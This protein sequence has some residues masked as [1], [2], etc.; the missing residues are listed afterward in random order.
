MVL[1]VLYFALGLALIIKGGDWFV[2]AS[3]WVAERTGMPKIF[4]GATV[5][6]LATTL[7]ELF[8]SVTAVAKGAVGLGIGNAIG[9]VICNTGLI[10]GL[11]IFIRPPRIERAHFILKAG[12]MVLSL[13]MLLVF[14]LDSIISIPEALALLAV[15]FIF[16]YVSLKSA[17]MSN[18]P[19]EKVQKQGN[20]ALN[21]LKFT[22][23]A[24]AIVIGAQLLVSNA[25]IIASALG[26]S[27][28]IIGLTVIALGT[29]LPELV[30]T[31][32]ALRKKE[33]AIGVGNI[34]GANIINICLVL[35]ASTFVAGRLT[36][37]SNFLPVLA[38]VMPRTLYIDIPVAALLFML[39]LIPPLIFRSKLKRFQGVLMLGVYAGFIA[40][41]AVNI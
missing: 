39:L 38:R 33:S 2:D 37:E 30:T 14:C 20:T 1:T 7:P 40:F 32:T 3:V 23:G 19:T 17:R 6:S 36:L 12:F 29:S 13:V 8:V 16:I 31:V 10:L 18:E 28:G 11:S 21:V 24:A 35:S 27:D 4:I 26:V 9:S 15:F 5:V 22:A 34:L 41:L 25:V